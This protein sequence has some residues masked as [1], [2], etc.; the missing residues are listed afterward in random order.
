MRQPL[1]LI[2]LVLLTAAPC[3]AGDGVS[4]Y[5]NE[6]DV[7]GLTGQTFEKVTVRIDEKGNVHID[8]PGY[9]IKRVNVEA[10]PAGK[11]EGVITRRYFLVSEQSREGAAGYD[12]DVVLNGRLLRTLAGADPQLVSELTRQLRP[13]RNTVVLQARKLRGDQRS[14][15]RADVLRVIIGE[16]TVSDEKVVLERQLVTFARTAADTDDVTQEFSFT[17]R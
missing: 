7:S 1:S 11:S 2:C 16:G 6:V 17:T 14:S 8:A 5:V 15:S 9:T 12:V 10:K 3:L 4:V 13:G